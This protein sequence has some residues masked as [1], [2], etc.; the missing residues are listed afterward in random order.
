MHRLWIRVRAAAQG[1]E[2]AQVNASQ[3]YIGESTRSEI[4]H[5]VATGKPVRY[6][7]PSRAEAT[8]TEEA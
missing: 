8:P 2:E 1:R 3:C 7:E 4:A 5:A 6:L